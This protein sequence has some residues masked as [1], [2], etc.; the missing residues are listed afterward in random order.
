MLVNERD[1]KVKEKR[2]KEEHTHGTKPGALIDATIFV[3]TKSPTIYLGPKT[4]WVVYTYTYIYIYLLTLHVHTL[5][6]H[7]FYG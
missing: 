1:H 2:S 3:P 7:P 4:K 5:N 6:E